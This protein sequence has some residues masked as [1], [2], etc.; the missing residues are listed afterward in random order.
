M[1]R[2]DRGGEKKDSVGQGGWTFLLE[3]GGGRA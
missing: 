3:G 2:G 1:R